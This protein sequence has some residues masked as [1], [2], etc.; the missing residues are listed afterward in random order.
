[1]NDLPSGVGLDKL[2]TIPKNWLE[3]FCWIEGDLQL[4]GTLNG[5]GYCQYKSRCTNAKKQ[6]AGCSFAVDRNVSKRDVYDIQ[7][8]DYNIKAKEI[9]YRHSSVTKGLL[10]WARSIIIKD[11]YLQNRPQIGIKFEIFISQKVEK[12][13]DKMIIVKKAKSE[14][15]FEPIYSMGPE[16]DLFVTESLIRWW[17]NKQLVE[18]VGKSMFIYK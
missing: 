16:S 12:K 5:I 1:M 15:F 13:G 2:K 4:Q 17:L 6:I 9:Y 18:K 7:S 14:F 3:N 11:K 10:K 8:V